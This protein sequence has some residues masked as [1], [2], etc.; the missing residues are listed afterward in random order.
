MLQGWQRFPR[1][2]GPDLAQD[3]LQG[4][5]ARRE[6]I[7]VGVDNPPE[8]IFKCCRFFVGKVKVH[9]SE[10]RLFANE[11]EPRR[12]KSERGAPMTLGNAA[13]AHVRLVKELRLARISTIEAANAWLPGFVE[14]YNERF[15]RAR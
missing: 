13:A 5:N 2:L 3:R 11:G 14:D 15:G 7:A 1:W 4:L 12:M 8:Q 6:R 9:A 10:M